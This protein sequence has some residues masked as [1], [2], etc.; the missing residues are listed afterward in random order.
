MGSERHQESHLDPPASASRSIFSPPARLGP[1]RVGERIGLGGVGV[2]HTAVHEPTGRAVA[3]KLARRD[4]PDL[5]SAIR[6]EIDV[7][8]RCQH[9]GIVRL[10][11]HSEES[12]RA[13]YAM[14]LLDGESLRLVLEERS[15][16]SESVPRS[17]ANT[18]RYRVAGT[19]RPVRPERLS[20]ALWI[21]RALCAPLAH[22][23]QVGLVHADV[24]PENVFVC[25]DGRVVLLDLGAARA[26]EDAASLPSSWEGTTFGTWSYMAPELRVGGA[27]DGRADAYSIGCILYEIVVGQTPAEHSILRRGSDPETSPAL[28]AVPKALAQLIRRLIAIESDRRPETLSECETELDA[29]LDRGVTPLGVQNA[30][31]NPAPYCPGPGVTAKRGSWGA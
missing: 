19:P 12:D 16:P 21:V 30:S 20:D 25:N 6:H 8:G 29:I 1:F 13:W 15:C 4:E 22:L 7:L 5:E 3:V 28:D 26:I 27:C 10:L 17:R 9:P 18:G 11:S 23:H 2:V 31:E 14:E 24:K